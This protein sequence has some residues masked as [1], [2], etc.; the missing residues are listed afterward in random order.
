MTDQYKAYCAEA[1]SRRPAV[2]AP[3]ATG[4][5]S[6]HVT[7]ERMRERFSDDPSELLAKGARTDLVNRSGRTGWDCAHVA[8]A[9]EVLVVLREFAVA[10][11]RR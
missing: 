9:I 8:G 11:T 2:P 3:E 7:L 4:A 5:S 6:A 1:E 10:G